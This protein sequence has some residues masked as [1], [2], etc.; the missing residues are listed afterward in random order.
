MAHKKG[1]GSVKSGRDSKP[2]MLG[3]KVYGED[4]VK[5]GGIIVRQRGTKFFPG[6]NTSL[7]KDFTIFALKQGKVKFRK[8]YGRQYVDVVEQK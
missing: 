3:I 4:T 7:G 2:K 6:E 8:K 5:S 1:G